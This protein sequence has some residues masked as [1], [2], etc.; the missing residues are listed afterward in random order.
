MEYRLAVY[1]ILRHA[2]E[3]LYLRRRNTG[4][5]DGYFSLIAGH[6]DPEESAAAAAIR[7]AQEETGINIEEHDLE[8]CGVMH[9]IAEVT[10]VDFFFNCHQWTGE[11]SNIEPD[12]CSELRWFPA[13]KQPENAIPYISRAIALSKGPVWFEEFR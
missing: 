12:K 8:I 10:Y 1:I 11:L 2:N 13:E 6:I 9:R 4:Y 5:K 7:E 3:I